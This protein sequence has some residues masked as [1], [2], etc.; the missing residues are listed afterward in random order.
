MGGGGWLKILKVMY[1]QPQLKIYMIVFAVNV[2]FKITVFSNISY[3]KIWWLV[4]P[5]SP[6]A[7]KIIL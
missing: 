6:Q 7:I 4:V 3:K 5:W 1:S 2:V